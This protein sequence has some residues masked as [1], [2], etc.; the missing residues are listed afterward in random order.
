MSIV[1]TPAVIISN[2][3]RSPAKPS[4]LFECLT[5]PA[6]FAKVGLNNK[7]FPSFSVSGYF[8]GRQLASSSYFDFS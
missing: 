1:R 6:G 3:T 4:E 7:K 2:A 8:F 5:M